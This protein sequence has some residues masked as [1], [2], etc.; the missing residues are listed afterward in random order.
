MRARPILTLSLLASAMALS[1]NAAALGLGRL[2]VQSALGQP[3][4]AQIELTSATREELDTLAAK[5]ADP[6]LYRQNNLTYQGVLTRARVSV[7]RRADGTSYL[8]VVVERAG[9]RALSRS[10]GRAQLGLGPR[11][12]R[13]HVP[14]RSSGYQRRR[15]RAGRARG[16]GACRRG[17]GTRAGRGPGRCCARTRRRRHVF[18]EARRHAVEDRQRIQAFGRHARP[19]AGR[20]VQGQCQRVRRQQHE[21]PAHRGDR[22][23]PERDRRR[24][25]PSPAR[26]RRSSA[27]RRPTGARTAIASP[28]RH[29]PRKA[30]VP[31]GVP[32]AARSARRSRKRRRPPCRAAISSR[33]PAKPDRARAAPAR[34]RKPS[35][36]TRRCRKRRRASR[37]SRRRSPICRGRSR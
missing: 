26:R 16:P 10:D 14:A 17:R 36:A 8:K 27:C 37:R 20:A 12:P 5:V 31:A 24:A 32:Q 9:Q 29:R 28:P 11:R 35:P 2:T 22:D 18:G 4:S 15:R 21:P 23:D 13:L 30:A 3:L 6:T 34:P 7:E 19:D 33:C 1:G 25:R